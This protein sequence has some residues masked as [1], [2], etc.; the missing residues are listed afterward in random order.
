MVT[1]NDGRISRLRYAK[2]S[3]YTPHHLNQTSSALIG[4]W[5][6]VFLPGHYIGLRWTTSKSIPEKTHYSCIKSN[7]FLGMT[8]APLTLKSGSS[9]QEKIPDFDVVC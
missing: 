6:V 2:S 5:T 1:S 8:T 4:I 7:T 9:K 3:K